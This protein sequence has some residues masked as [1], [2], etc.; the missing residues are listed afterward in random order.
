MYK[1]MIKA[2]LHGSKSSSVYSKLNNLLTEGTEMTK[3][4]S[5]QIRI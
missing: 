2:V 3:N 1:Q 4:I 5:T